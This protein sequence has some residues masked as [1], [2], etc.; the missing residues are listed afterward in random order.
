[1]RKGEKKKATLKQSNQIRWIRKGRFRL[2]SSAAIP[3]VV[4]K[5][6]LP[7]SLTQSPALLRV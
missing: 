1:M 5:V 6:L 2:L 4:G 3:P 7:P